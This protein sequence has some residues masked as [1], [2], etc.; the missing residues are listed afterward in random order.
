MTTSNLKQTHK[1][2]RQVIPRVRE[3]VSASVSVVWG[4]AY[5]ILVA[6]YLT[7]L[8]VL[9]TEQYIAR[10]RKNPHRTRRVSNGCQS[11]ERKSTR[12]PRVSQPMRI[13]RR[14]VCAFSSH[15]RSADVPATSRPTAEKERKKNNNNVRVSR[16]NG[17][18]TP[19][20]HHGG[21]CV[22]TTVNGRQRAVVQPLEA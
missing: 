11:V 21:T 1:A 10:E 4:S 12:N 6:S 14:T 2:T 5:V 20:N 13:T 9:S 19:V 16:R 17:S 15:T 18:R 7:K 22:C 3:P 8:R